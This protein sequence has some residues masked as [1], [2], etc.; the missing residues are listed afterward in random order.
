MYGNRKQ[1]LVT[2]LYNSITHCVAGALLRE[3]V[4]SP[5]RSD[6]YQKRPNKKYDLGKNV[7]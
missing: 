7:V 1:G 3:I 5:A 4:V 2:Q 6:N